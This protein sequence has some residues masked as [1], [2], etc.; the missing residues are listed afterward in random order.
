MID[1]PSEYIQGHRCVAL[2]ELGKRGPF[3]ESCSR[4]LNGGDVICRFHIGG[5]CNLDNSVL[6]GLKAQCTPEKWQK[7]VREELELLDAD[8]DVMEALDTVIAS[9]IATFPIDLDHELE[10]WVH[11]I[12]ALSGIMMTAP[13]WKND[14]RNMIEHFVRDL[15]EMKLG[16]ANLVTNVSLVLN[17]NA[18]EPS[19]DAKRLAEQEDKAAK[20]GLLFS[21]D[22]Y[23]AE[24]HLLKRIKELE[25]RI[26]T[27]E[28]RNG[29]RKP[30]R[31]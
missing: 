13:N 22:P 15:S 9:G 21:S 4:R 12:P 28:R 8:H 7:K 6:D 29:C 1:F 25:R 16:I 3:R 2:Y 24:A 11:G 31:R 10:N 30:S 23:K 19:E 18:L 5:I 26:I 20:E 14:L 27:L 17:S